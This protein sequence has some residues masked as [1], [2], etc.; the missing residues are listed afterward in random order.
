M[1]IAKIIPKVEGLVWPKPKEEALSTSDSVE[2]LIEGRS[3]NDVEL[4]G[5]E[6]EG[7][8]KS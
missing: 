3:E 7:N 1:D 2:A 6:G 8:S 5:V 4:R